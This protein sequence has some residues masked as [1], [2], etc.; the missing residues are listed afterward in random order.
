MLSCPNTDC[1]CLPYIGQFNRCSTVSITSQPARHFPSLSGNPLYLVRQCAARGDFPVRSW[2]IV[3]SSCRVRLGGISFG[4]PW[5]QDESLHAAVLWSNIY[6]ANLINSAPLLHTQL[7]SKRNYSQM[8]A[9]EGGA[10][11]NANVRYF[12]VCVSTRRSPL[13]G[14]GQTQTWKVPRRRMARRGNGYPEPGSVPSEHSRYQTDGRARP[15][16]GTG[17]GSDRIGLE[18]S[19]QPPEHCTCA[20]R[21]P[22][23]RV[24]PATYQEGQSGAKRW[25]LAVNE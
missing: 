25:A 10:F 7:E 20:Q 22:L 4:T 17:I 14:A 24:E 6:D 8:D 13:R 23:C 1:L 5:D 21:Q 9:P 19:D 3:I 11:V 12:P 18:R 15:D 2:C 16:P